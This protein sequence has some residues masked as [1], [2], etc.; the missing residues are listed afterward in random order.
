MPN[1]KNVKINQFYNIGKACG[2][3]NVIG[4]IMSYE[5][6]NNFPL[7]RNMRKIKVVC[8][9]IYRKSSYV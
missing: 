4:Q 8:W 3:T 9:K 6:I 2:S 1:W 5:K 7:V